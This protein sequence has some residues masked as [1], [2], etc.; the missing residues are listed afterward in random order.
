MMSLIEK[1][2]SDWMLQC[3]VLS[4]F[5]PHVLVP[6]I[7]SYIMTNKS[8][9]TVKR[10][11]CKILESKDVWSTQFYSTSYHLMQQKN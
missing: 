5:L 8:S 11:I 3:N 7:K 4:G 9:T 10:H 1:F 2:Y 6:R